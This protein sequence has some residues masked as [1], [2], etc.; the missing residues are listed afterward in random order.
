MGLTANHGGGYQ[1]RLC[2]LEKNSANI[3]SQVTEE[4]FQQ[5]PLKFK[6]HKQWIQW[7]NGLDVNN[8]TE[9][10]AVRVKKGV[11][12]KGSTW[13]KNPIPP[14]NDVPRTGGHNHKCQGPMFE[15]P[16]PG[17]FGFGPGS[18]A[19]GVAPCT[20]EE[21]AQR[22][23]PFGIVDR[24]KVPHHLPEGEYVLGFRWDC[25]QLPQVWANCADVTIK[26]KHLWH[27]PKATKAFSAWS[28]CE[29][30]C[31]STLGPCANCSKCLEDKTGDCA[32]CWSPLPGY[33]FGAMPQYQ[34][35]GYEGPDGG[36]GIWEVGMPFV[37]KL[38]SPGC[39]K[40][41]KTPGSCERSPRE[42]EDHEHHDGLVLV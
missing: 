28:G 16:A 19:S 6:G 15:P 35:L 39:S 32:K 11:W 31:A 41:W 40:C 18:C 1:Y 37:G 4:C 22:A 3:T 12:P 30:C 27:T 25:E 29:Q 33:S 26:K 9:I 14:C 20:A 34:C 10:R 13:T 42:S 21:M 23:F 38:W 17:L 8:R 5:T 7:G 2:R 36:P 24:V